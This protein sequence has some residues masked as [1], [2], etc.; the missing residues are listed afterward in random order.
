[1]SLANWRI[2]HK[3]FLLIGVLSL[4][5]IIVAIAG[6][7]GITQMGDATDRV[8][9]TGDEALLGSRINQNVVALNR[10]EYQMAVDPQ[11]AE[12][13]LKVIAEQRDQ[14]I[15]RLSTLRLTA[16]KDQL[17]L[18]DGLERELKAYLPEL[19]DTIATVRRNAARVTLSEAQKEIRDS[20]TESRE[21]AN[22]L[23]QAAREYFNYSNDRSGEIAK[24]AADLAHTTRLT[25][26]T[27][28]IV[29]VLGG[30][31]IG[32]LVATLT[33]TRPIGKSV[34]SL[35]QLAAGDLTAEVHGLG[36]K[37]EIGHVAAGLQ[38][39]KDNLIRAR[40]VEQEAK[41]AEV[42]AAQERRATMLKL[43]DE[44]EGSVKGV[45]ESVTSSAVELQSS[46]QSMTAIAT[47]TN[48]Q[49]GA[50]AAATEQA[51]ANVQTVAS[52]TEE[53]GSSIQEIARQVSESSQISKEAEREA[54]QTNQTVAS[55]AETAQRIGMV[56]Q[57]ISDIASQTNLLALNA[58]IEAARAGE[59][60]KG[61][62]VVA[63]EVKSLANQTA[64]ATEEIGAQIAAVQSQTAAA[65]TAI[66]AISGT[67]T[68]LSEIAGSIASA[69]E[70]QSAATR[71]I[72]RN[73]QQ[74][75]EG[76]AEVSSNITGVSS[77]AGEAGS[78]ASQV[79]AA[80]GTL[81]QEANHLQREVGR[82]ITRVRQG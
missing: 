35:N 70:E 57:L 61:F 64:K 56:V 78:A 37:D 60:G 28:A 12:A 25:M 39:F 82:F 77:A 18:L 68:R 24:E 54:T 32:W 74:A 42:R 36:R 44:F 49:A 2:I 72:G 80:A 58:T 17:R 67:V 21:L 69:V 55:L 26:L 71:E 50:V 20:V 52:A 79:L 29:G 47:Q 81:S 6:V 13:A 15:E 5:T 75:A 46:A 8:Q 51:A 41:E 23:Q 66:G 19:E 45:V 9:Q 38:I 10:A 65:V 63:S 16:N 27:V 53:L 43:A 62:A 22:R 34:E 31:V 1:M 11:Q 3:L 73:V 14:L 48:Q 76:T 7:T 30:I 40:Q 59:A 33:I 4:V